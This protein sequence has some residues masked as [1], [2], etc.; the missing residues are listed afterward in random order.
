MSGSSARRILPRGRSRGGGHD[1]ARRGREPEATSPLIAPT[2]ARAIIAAVFCGFAGVALLLMPGLGH[3]AGEIALAAALLS[4]LL[5]LQFFYFSRPG[6][7]LRTRTAHLALAAQACLVYLP[8]LWYGQVW[9]SQPPFLA[10]S[11]LLVFRPRVAW[12]LFGAVVTGTAV[13]QYVVT[14][15]P[16][17]ITYI[18]VNSVT[19]GLYVYGLT[20]LARLVTALYEARDE[21]ANSAVTHERLR[22]ARSLH[23]LLGL[24]LSAI[25]LKGQ[26]TLRL[27]RPNPDR[28]GQELSEILEIAQRMLADVRSIAREYRVTSPS[29]SP[30]AGPS[31]SRV[32]TGPADSLVVA[33]FAGLFLQ[34]VLRQ[35]DGTRD[36]AEISLATGCMLAALALQLGYFSRPA[37]RPG[38]PAAYLLLA[39]Q[40]VLVYAPTL[41]YQQPWTG[42]HGF[43]AGSALLVL[44]PAIGWSVFAAVMASMAGAE[45]A[46]GGDLPADFGQM[47]VAADLGLITYG[48]TWMARSVRRLRAARDELAELA[49]A[50]ARLRW[51]QDVHDLLGLSLSAI[52]LK[53]D[54]AHRLI[55]R[56]PD[57]ARTVLAEALEI[58]RHAL[59]DVRSVTSGRPRMSL[60]EECRTTRSLLEAAGL[61]VRM[62]VRTEGDLP[63]ETGTVLAMVLREGVTN[64]LRH[65]RGRHCEITVAGGRD[66]VR[67]RI[68]NDGAAARPADADQAG[69]GIR[70]M[71]ARVA[72][73]G[74]V[75]AAGPAGEDRFELSARIPATAGR[76]PVSPCPE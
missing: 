53:C 17:D 34:G 41:L 9:V 31:T 1:S 76:P 3:D 66:G 24:N 60:D 8:L 14:G 16:L 45:A 48:L 6:R 23:D 73:L 18:F 20:R 19:A 67:L 74:G 33:V 63:A 75:L 49:L 10:G 51:A 62:D 43:V 47:L 22:F 25:A 69:S 52:T 55:A 38:P 32:A 58:S 44:R 5:G 39:L 54:L 42:M 59:A 29:S 68:A 15:V 21:L 4:G 28:A 26:V 2:L 65:S 30:E 56:D 72:A 70:N 57:R 7:N 37:A 27:L 46:F 36:V 64:V 12:P 61:D 11:V 40:A 71:S 35:F 50:E 13:A